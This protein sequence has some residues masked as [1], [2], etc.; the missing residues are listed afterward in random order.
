LAVRA[1]HRVVVGLRGNDI[2]LNAHQQ[3]LR[4]GQRQTQV[5]DITKTF[6]PADRHHVDTSGLT[7]HPR[8]N[9]S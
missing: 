2:L 4:L 9:Q 5:S 7:I 8:S 3:L 6:R 1:N